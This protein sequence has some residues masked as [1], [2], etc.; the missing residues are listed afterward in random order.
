M[1]QLICNEVSNDVCLVLV[2]ADWEIQD[3]QADEI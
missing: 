2:D 3:F 1:T